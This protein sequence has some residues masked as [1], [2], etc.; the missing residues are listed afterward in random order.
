[1]ND[2]SKISFKS[3]INIISNN[4][5]Y[6]KLPRGQYITF[7]LELREPCIARTDIFNTVNIR[8]CTG[9]GLKSEDNILAL[10]FHL[11]DHYKDKVFKNQVKFIKKSLEKPDGG[12][13]IGSKR[14]ENAPKSVTNFL[15]L[16]NE[17]TKMTP[18]ISWF[19]TIKKEYG[20]VDF[21]Y[22]RVDDTWN[23]RLLDWGKDGERCKQVNSLKRLLDFFEEISI[24]PQDRL[25]ING[26]EI[27]EKEAPQI[28]RKKQL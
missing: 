24:S 15:K 4:K 2:F 3:R 28:F 20:E 19:Q 12:L 9:G 7:L 14:V 25:F 16:K 22:S 13:L 10:G 26:K 1:M 11:W 17:L 23:L 5:I 8:T 18:N 6:E 21:K 27:T